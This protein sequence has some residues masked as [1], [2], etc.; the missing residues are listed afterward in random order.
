MG[1]RLKLATRAFGAEPGIPDVTALAAW[2]VGH[3]GASADL[4]S[5]LLDQSLAPQIAAEIGIP[6]AG[7]KFCR[8]RILESLIGVHDGNAIDE[9]G[10]CTEVIIEDTAQLVAQKNGVWCALPAPHA[11][12]ITYTYYDDED[13]WHDAIAGVYRTIMRAMRDAGIGGNVLICDTM[14]EG[15]ISALAR[16]NVFFFQPDPDRESL[17]TLMEHQRRIAVGKDQLN[18][19]FDLANEYELLQ[20]ILVDADAES[21]ARTLSHLDPDQIMVGGYCTDMCETYWKSLVDSATY[22]K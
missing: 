5:Y 22:L 19:V 20:I 17:G 10:V 8:D 11:L 13:E 3:R 18:A 4:I 15:E 9:L 2:V 12:R 1:K 14:D 16:Q 21:I 6:C 7:G